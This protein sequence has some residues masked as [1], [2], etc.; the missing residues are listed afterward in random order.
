[1]TLAT[2]V[3]VIF[4]ALFREFGFQTG[5]ALFGLSML[6]GALFLSL[7]GLLGLLPRAIGPGWFGIRPGYGTFVLAAFV[8]S[9]FFVGR[10]SSASPVGLHLALC[11]LSDQRPIHPTS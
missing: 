6:A 5:S 1:M 7:F 8:V 10:L 4:L 2:A 11:F 9:L 3:G